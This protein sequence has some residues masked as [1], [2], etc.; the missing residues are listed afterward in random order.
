MGC[1]ETERSCNTAIGSE[2]AE[3]ET[4]SLLLLSTT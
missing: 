1:K 3:P 4:A 2:H